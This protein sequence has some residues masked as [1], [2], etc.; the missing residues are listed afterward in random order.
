MPNHRENI[1][2]PTRTLS[3]FLTQSL[4]EDRSC[5][6]AVNDLIIQQQRQNNRLKISPNTG[7]YCLTRKKHL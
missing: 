1:Y 6:K 5:S 7:A 2:T 4:N 3:M